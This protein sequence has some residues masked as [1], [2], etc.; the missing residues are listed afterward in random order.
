MIDNNLLW[1]VLLVVN[2]CMVML[3]FRL[4]KKE[5][6]FAWIVISSILA[7]I[8]V[9]K[10]VE[11]FGFVTTLGNIMYGTSF[12]V[13]DIL[14]E[15]YSKDEARKAVFIG[16]FSLSVT[17]AVM[18]LCLLFVPH[19]SDIAHTSLN[20]IFSIMPRVAL[21][22]IFSYVISQ[23]FDVWLFHYLKERYPTY[24]WLRNNLST[25]VSQF[26]DNIIFTLIAFYGVFETN[27]LWQI[28]I[29]TY[30]LKWVVALFDTP[31]IYWARSWHKRVSQ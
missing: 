6:L 16:I 5:G 27:I 20:S 13:T 22:S 8:Q 26:F 10:T 29:S 1:L 23:N 28:F 7:N 24:L 17:T 15:C 31:V 14:G 19:S 21:A 9:L 3:S 11:L 4:F 25:M 12:L 2:Y 18:Q 30:M